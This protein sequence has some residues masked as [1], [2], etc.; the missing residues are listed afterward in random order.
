MAFLYPSFLW[1]LTAL[2]IPIA[3]HLFQLRRFKRIDFPNVRFLQAVSQQTRARKKVQHW[4]TLLARCLAIAALV[5]AFAQPY[6]PASA[7]TTPTGKQAV[8]LFLDDSWSM[9]AQNAEGRLLDQARKSAQDAVLAYEPT[10]EF[11]VLTSRLD[12]R[13]QL[14]IGRDEAL[15]AAGQVE[16]GPFSRKISL[17]LARQQEAL[18]RSAAP[19]KRAVLFTDLQRSTTDVENWVNDTT[20]RTVI[21]PL[22]PADAANLSVDSAWFATPVRRAG[23]AEALHVRIRNLGSAALKDVPLRLAINGQQRALATFSVEAEA[24]TDTV[25][26]FTSDGP[27]AHWGEISISDRPITFDD[28]L[29]VAWEVS[30]ALRVQLLSG[31]D[32]TSDAA[33]AS[34]FAADSSFRLTVTPSGNID[35]ASLTSTDLL[36]LNA[37][38][39]VSSGFAQALVNFVKSGGSLAVFPSLEQETTSVNGFLAQL[40]AGQYGQLDTASIKVAGI[41]LR[42]PFYRDVFSDVPSNVDLPLVR[43]RLRLNSVAGAE[44]LLRMQDGNAF[45]TRT[46]S[47][48]GVVN[49]CAAPLSDVGGSFTRHALFV[50]SLLRMA[51]LSRPMGALYHNIGNDARIPLDGVVIEGDRVP[52]MIG[53]DGVDRVPELR[54]SADAH[55][56]LMHDEAMPA[57]AYAVT[58]GNDTVRHIA[59]N[60]PRTE[61]D[62]S[63]YTAAELRTLIEQR[64]LTAFEVLEPG[65]EAL[66][67]SLAALDHGRKLWTWF[68]VLALIFLSLEVA[69][70]R[71]LK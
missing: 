68:V 22:A 4:L 26:H 13:Q 55:A 20:V 15:D 36:I 5:L 58:L 39:E 34:V 43:Q 19:R 9:D 3:I 71:L 28:K 44:T 48:K 31:G 38:P 60:T 12:G 41:D 25:L 30:S 2:A 18:A 69:F 7:G 40:G 62:P 23:Q 33:V 42:L 56:L 63:A 64:G 24:F 27:G 70:L 67:V 52:H 1:A 50:T 21:V 59:L 14:L 16:A 53:P 29:F 47:G 46:N 32:E 57:G 17:V 35:L 8:S 51:E 6:I 49:V 11:Q 37:L 65:G 45:L 61:S 66:S 10:T 54:R